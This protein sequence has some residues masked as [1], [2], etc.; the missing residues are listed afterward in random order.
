M[1]TASEGGPWGMAILAAYMKNGKGEAFADYLSGRVFAGTECSSVKPDAADVA[2]F[3]KFIERYK[4]GFAVERAA[5]EV[6][7]S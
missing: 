6:F 4:A 5:T 7:H 3:A 1:A 2:G